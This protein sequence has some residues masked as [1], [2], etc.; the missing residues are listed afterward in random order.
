MRNEKCDMENLISF[1]R[2]ENL[3][4]SRRRKI[5]SLLTAPENLVYQLESL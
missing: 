4:F 3:I 5:W 2:P 1:D